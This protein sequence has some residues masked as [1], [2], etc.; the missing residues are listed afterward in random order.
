M[1]AVGRPRVQKVDGQ[2][3]RLPPSLIPHIIIIAARKMRLTKNTI[4]RKKDHADVQRIPG[5]APFG[6]KV[7][8]RQ[9]AVAQSLK[10]S[11]QRTGEIS[12]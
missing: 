4:H 5:E 2:R 9:E 11:R 1:S 12:Q 3:Y 6:A 8:C 10:S 7:R